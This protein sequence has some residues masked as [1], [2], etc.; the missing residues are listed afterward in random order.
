[1]AGGIKTPPV[2]LNSHRKPRCTAGLFLVLVQNRPPRVLNIQKGFMTID[3]AVW[4]EKYGPMVI[5]RCRFLLRNEE[6]AMDAV[7]DVFLN[8]LKAKKPLHG[9]F[10][11]SLLYTMATN[12][13]L[14]RLRTRKREVNNESL[15]NGEGLNFD[16]DTSYEQIDA[17]LLSQAILE[18]ETEEMRAICFMYYSDGMTFKEIGNA[19]G[20]SISGVR[21]KLETFKERVRQKYN[22]GGKK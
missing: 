15:S 1:M 9:T 20:M 7:Q 11:S 13:C 3:V 6:E 10:P 17:E 2:S 8:L 19:V 5:R 21:K 4:Y 18:D 16:I 22:A 12:V 14:N